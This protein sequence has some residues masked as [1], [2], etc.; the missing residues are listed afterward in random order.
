MQSEDG[1]TGR[2][3]VVFNDRGTLTDV[4]DD[5]YVLL[6]ERVGFGRLPN[7]KVNDIQFRPRWR[8]VACHR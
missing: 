7:P 5:R 4:R 1:V 6:D 8:C 3:I 2:G